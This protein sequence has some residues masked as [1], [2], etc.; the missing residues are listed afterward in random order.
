MG[1]SGEPR[2]MVESWTETTSA[3]DRVE[4]IATTLTEPRT[5]NWVAEQAEVKWDTAEKYLTTLVERGE[6]LQTDDGAYYPDPTHAYF[7]QL[8]TLLVENEKAELRDELEAIASEIDGWREEY[9]VDSPAELEATLGED[10]AAE[11][12]RTRREVLRH[13]EENQQYR[14]L[15]TQALS[16]YDDV[17][18]RFDPRVANRTE[19]AR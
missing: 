13:W 18:D 6:L 11:E 7:R 4:T 16:M 19:T 2:T 17:M 14:S 8:R 12:V 15:F 9:D 1:T 3:K 10:L 5:A